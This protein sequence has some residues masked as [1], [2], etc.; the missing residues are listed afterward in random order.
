[1]NFSTK[2]FVTVNEILSDVLEFVDDTEL[3][4]HSKG[5]YTSQIQQ[6]LEKLAFDT[7]FDEK[8]TDHDFPQDLRLDMPRGCWN[9]KQI[10]LFNGDLCNI[11]SAQNVYWKRN[12]FTKGQG[13]LARDTGKNTNDPFYARNIRTVDAHLSK[14]RRLANNGADPVLNDINSPSGLFFYNI[15]NGVIMFSSQCR[16]F[17]KVALY[18][19][20]VGTEIGDV[21]V[22]PLFLREAVVDYT[23]EVSLR[24]KAAK[25]PPRWRTLWVDA[26]NRLGSSESFSGSWYR[27]ETRAKFLDSKARED[28]KEYMARLNY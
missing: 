28:L 13:F 26:S 15:Q 2:D 20:G 1:M 23:T 11:N 22:V 14:Q 16:A 6:A 10:Y 19:N 24:I 8:T 7:Y 21:P 5:Y 12:Y 25:N 4:D 17:R 18:Y 3:R 27:A 9:I